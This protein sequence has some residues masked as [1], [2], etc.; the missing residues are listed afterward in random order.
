MISPVSQKDC[1][2]SLSIY[3][4][5]I[6]S[7]KQYVTQHLLSLPLCV[8]NILFY[9]STDIPIHPFRWCWKQLLTKQ[10]YQNAFLSK[11]L[12]SSQ[13]A[14]VNLK[15]KVAHTSPHQT[16]PLFGAA[17]ATI[18]NNRQPAIFKNH[19]WIEAWICLYRGKVKNKHETLEMGHH[20]LCSSLCKASSSLSQS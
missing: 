15:S 8:C 18:D 7:H 13:S 2:P 9:I 1:N 19:C 17:T 20:C 12:P 14:K 16:A 11:P 5:R 10:I 4:S 6:K 3:Y